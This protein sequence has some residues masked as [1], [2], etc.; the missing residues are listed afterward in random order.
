MTDRIDIPV[1]A[2]IELPS[3]FCTIFHLSIGCGTVRLSF[4]EYLDKQYKFRTAVSIPLSEA[5][6]LANAIVTMTADTGT[7][8]H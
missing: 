7:H 5:H 3:F 2:V 6:N 8:Q 4:G 1:D